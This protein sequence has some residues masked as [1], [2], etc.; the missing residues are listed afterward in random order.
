[1]SDTET[2][3][4]TSG[5]SI[6]IESTRNSV[7]ISSQMKDITVE[8]YKKININSSE[9][10]ANIKA[11][12]CVNIIATEK[13]INLK[14]VDGE[15]NAISKKDI[16]LLSTHGDALLK[17]YRGELN[18]ETYKNMEILSE[19]GNI[20]IEAP[21]GTVN[22]RAQHNINITPGETGQVYVA[23]NLRATTISQ[24]SAN[25][26]SGLLVPP[27]TVVPYCASS[28]PIGWFLCNGSSYSIITYKPLFDVI[29]Y[30]FGGGE[31]GGTFQ[32][33]DLRGR[34]ILGYSTGI[35]NISNK[36]I[37]DI[38]GSETHTLTVPEMPSHNHTVD[39]DSISGWEESA[40]SV[41]GAPY[42]PNKGSGIFTTNSTGGGQSHP[43][44][45]PYM[46][47]N[48]IIKY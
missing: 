31:S 26:Q 37:G 34:L 41:D 11:H 1:M 22:I 19:Q 8:S 9:D 6:N 24:G 32:V 15:V 5:K 25:E 38:G 4:S 40:Y 21:N 47:L 17:A 39:I 36:E 29:G 3:I 30:T 28:S 18:I 45:Q 43:I 27:G 13:S 44:M 20:T 46:A 7:T 14:A 10:N 35:S 42:R 2:D 12:H 33:P 48:Y 16:T 23:G